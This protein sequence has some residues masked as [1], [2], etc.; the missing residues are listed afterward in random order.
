MKKTLLILIVF[1]MIFSMMF[2]VPSGTLIETAFAESY[3]PIPLDATKGGMPLASGYSADGLSYQDET[4]SVN[5]RTDRAY[6]TTIYL[7]TIQIKDPSQIRTAMAGRYGSGAKTRASNIATRA[8]SVFAINGD[9]FNFDNY[10]FLV[11]QGHLYRNRPRKDFDI[12]IID[13]KG[14]FHIIREATAEKCEAFPGTV[15]NSFSFGPAL[16]VDGEPVESDYIQMNIGYNKAT[17]RMV[18]SQT[19]PLTYLC[20]AT[21]GPEN[22]NSVGLTLPEIRAYMD[23]LDVIHAYNLDGGSSSTMVFQNEKINSLSSGK[24]RYVCDILYFATML[25]QE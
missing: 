14:D 15:I 24:I 22:T 7:A 21:E 4:I 13:D 23:S 12:L 25:N 18:V 9:F 3:T 11:R 2:L 5:I 20:V 10:G 1:L 16:I 19:A 8:Q 17:Q 6:N